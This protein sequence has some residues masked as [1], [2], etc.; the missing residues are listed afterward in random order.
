MLQKNSRTILAL[1]AAVLLI[2]GLAGVYLWR[3]ITVQDGAKTTVLRQP[4]LKVGQALYAAQVTLSPADR[5]TPGLESWI[6]LDGKIQIEHANHVYVWDNGQAQRL[7]SLKSTPAA[8]LAE[9][10]VK[11]GPADRLKW[12][13]L[14]ID[15]NAPLPESGEQ[16]WQIQR[17]TNFTVMDAGEE[18][19]LLTHGPSVAHGLWEAG[20]QVGPGDWLSALPGQNTQAASSGT[21]L[22][23]AR[24]RPLV[25]AAQGAEIRLRTAAATVGEALSEAGVTL[26]GLDYSQPAESEPIPENGRIEVVRV[27]EELL[28]EQTLLPYESSLQPDPELELD[29]RSVMVPGQYGVLVS[30]HRVRY[31]NGQEISRALDSDW[32]AAQP[33]NE[34]MGYGTKIVPHTLDTPD[35]TIEY[36]RA[37]NVYATSYSPCRLGRENY[38]NYQTASGATLTKGIIAVSQSWYRMLVGSRVYVPGY[39]FGTI[40]DTGYGIPG[41][42]WIDLGYDEDNYPGGSPRYVTMYFLTPAPPN[43]PWTLP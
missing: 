10:G 7:T 2:A 41:T 37:V 26:Q 42:P 30:R 22:S 28:F 24:A 36:Y 40:A 8:I 12:N 3:P 27:T 5:V 23:V 39:G 11:L 31:E 13:G 17:A 16:V 21:P 33:Q 14:E 6:P 43:V 34:I 4:M 35:G 1:L 25:I 29:Q 38:C 32:T 18:R 19:T 9:A 20:V 15:L